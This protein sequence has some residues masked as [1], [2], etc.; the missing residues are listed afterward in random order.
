LLTA[1]F[2]EE[3]AASIFTLCPESEGWR[4]LRRFVNYP[5]AG[6]SFG[7][8]LIIRWLEIPPALY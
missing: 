5:M 2:L 4:F 1:K 3:F 7:A 8:L 6:D